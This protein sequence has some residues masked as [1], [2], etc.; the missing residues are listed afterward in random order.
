MQSQ[1]I[2]QAVEAGLLLAILISAEFGVASTD[3][4]VRILFH[5][6]RAS[7][8][9]SASSTDQQQFRRRVT[10]GISFGLVFLQ[11]VDSVRHVGDVDSTQES[12]V[13]EATGFQR[14]GSWHFQKSSRVPM[15]PSSQLNPGSTRGLRNQYGLERVGRLPGLQARSRLPRRRGAT[16]VSNRACVFTS[17]CLVAL[18]AGQDRRDHDTCL[19]IRKSVRTRMANAASIKAS[20]GVA[21]HFCSESR[22]R[23]RAEPVRASPSAG[24]T[25]RRCPDE[26]GPR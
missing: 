1:V 2:L 14:G 20:A 21:A 24:E 13:T 26:R 6:G 9:D 3:Q 7:E 4:I 11:I 22:F 19:N 12:P 17:F 5:A 18:I 23:P 16:V 25:G 15:E 10:H 8:H